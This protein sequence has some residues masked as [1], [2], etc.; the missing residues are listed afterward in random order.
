MSIDLEVAPI[1]GRIHKIGAVRSDREDD[2]HRAGGHL[3][4]A[5]QALDRYA[6]G[7]ECVLGHNIIKH[8]LKY[9]AAADPRLALFQLPVID[10]L[11]LNPLAFPAHPYH[12]LVKHY[13]DGGL[14]RG[15]KNDPVLDARLALDA[16]DNQRAQ[17]GDTHPDLLGAWHFLCTPDHKRQDA[18]LDRVFCELRGAERPSKQEAKRLI[19]ARLAGKAC[20]SVAEKLADKPNRHG[21]PL[22]YALAWLSVAGGNSVMPPWVAHQFPLAKRLVR[23]LRDKACG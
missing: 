11:R 21:W 17:F 10:T 15:Q 7:A 13:Q 14:L 4:A 12:H 5:L 9:L 18:A 6:H 8:D 16:F 19:L 23:D 2:F 22:A 3:G 1:D 20:S